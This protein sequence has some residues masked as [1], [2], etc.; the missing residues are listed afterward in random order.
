ME[1]GLYL[2]FLKNNTEYSNS[3]RYF[4]IE[5][6][7]LILNLDK[8][9]H[10]NLVHTKLQQLNTNIF[11]LNPK[12]ILHII[13]MIELLHQQEV[14]EKE[15]QFIESYTNN[16]LKYHDLAV[17]G[18]N[19]DQNTLFCLNIP[20]YYAYDPNLINNAGS[21][22]VRNIINNHTEA[23]ESTHGKHPKLVLTTTI[24]TPVEEDYLKEFEKAGFTTLLLIAGAV[25]G[26]CIYIIN[27]ILNH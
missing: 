10:I 4:S 13:Y 20:I 11:L 25:V 3:L 27:F 1:N 14:S 26:S 15:T 22:I 7:K 9:Y 17:D 24:S 23:Y 6:N 18:E 12:E 21:I 16:Y 5:G 2:Q 8:E 19:V